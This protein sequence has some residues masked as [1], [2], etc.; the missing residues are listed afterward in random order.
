MALEQF[1][2][3]LLAGVDLVKLKEL[4]HKDISLIQYAESQPQADKIFSIAE[5]CLMFIDINDIDV[6]KVI[7]FLQ[8]QRPDISAIV[9]RR[10]VSK[11]L[12]E[13]KKKANV[14]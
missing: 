1:F 5:W 11:Q 2:V 4:V 9:T 7:E 12:E 10:W 13:F 6:N 8:Q 14:G 3:T